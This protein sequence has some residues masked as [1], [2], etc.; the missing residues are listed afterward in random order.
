[1]S[2]RRNFG[3]VIGMAILM[4]ASVA[5]AGTPG[6]LFG[7]SKAGR[8]PQVP[9]KMAGGAQAPRGYS[10]AGGAQAPRGFSAAGGAGAQ[11]T[12]GFS[13]A[14][15]A[16][17]QAARGFAGAGEAQAARGVHEETGFQGDLGIEEGIASQALGLEEGDVGLEEDV[18]L[19]EDFEGQE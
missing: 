9:T 6:G 18:G 12:R 11:A 16:G 15:G 7:P 13:A 8:A 4:V 14:G 19:T 17:A 2:K 3:M 1:M 5:S 10:A